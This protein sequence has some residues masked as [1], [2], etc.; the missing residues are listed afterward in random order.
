MIHYRA[1][2]RYD[3]A[4]FLTTPGR[5]FMAIAVL[6]EGDR[7]ALAMR[8]HR[9]RIR[10]VAI[11]RLLNPQRTARQAGQSFFEGEGH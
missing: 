1:V 6:P 9:K 3:V 4:V 10:R 5:E 8:A 7:L 11:K 2:D